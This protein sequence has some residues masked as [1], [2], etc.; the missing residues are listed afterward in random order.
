MRRYRYLTPSEARK[1]EIVV[2]LGMLFD[3]TGDNLFLF[4]NVSSLYQV[5]DETSALLDP[6][7][8]YMKVLLLVDSL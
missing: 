5:V 4:L 6:K 2:S 1:V 7:C 8:A 3:K